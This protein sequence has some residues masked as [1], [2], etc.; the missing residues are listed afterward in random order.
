MGAPSAPLRPSSWRSRSSAAMA[1]RSTSRLLKMIRPA[2]NSA[3]QGSN[4]GLGR[5]CWAFGGWCWE[6][7]PDGYGVGGGG[8]M[9]GMPMLFW[10]GNFLNPPPLSASGP[11]VPPNSTRARVHHTEC[12]LI[13]L[14]RA[15]RQSVNQTWGQ[16]RTWG[17]RAAQKLGTGSEAARVAGYGSSSLAWA[18]SHC[19]KAVCRSGFGDT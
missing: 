15:I 4:V 13:R 12:S 7:D 5:W 18:N 11:S 1:L 17:Q 10:E 16:N 19:A 14:R 8:A 3:S 6:E 2:G 9:S